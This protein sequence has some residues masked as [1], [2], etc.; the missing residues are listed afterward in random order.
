MRNIIKLLIVLIAMSF[1]LSAFAFTP[2]GLLEIHY[3]NVQTG[4]ATL[5]IGPDGT[6]LLMDAGENGKGYGEVIPYMQSIGLMPADDLD[7]MIAGHLHSDH[8]GGLDEVIYSGYNVIGAVYYSG[9]STWNSVVEDF[10]DAAATTTA[11]GPDVMALNTVIDLGDGATARCV[12]ANGSVLGGGYVSGSNE[13]DK[14]IAILVTYGEFEYIFASDLSGGDDDEWCTYRHTATNYANVETPLSNSLV[15]PSGANL[16]GEDGLEVMHV[17][18]HGSESST[19]NDYMDNL[20]PSVAC[21][22]VGWNQPDGWDFPRHDILDNVLLAEAPGG[23][24]DADPAMVFQTEEGSGNPDTYRSDR[25]YAVGDIIITTNGERLFLVDGTGQVSGGSDERSSAGLPRYFPLDE[26]A[27]DIIDPDAITNLTANG[28]PGSDEI[29]LNWTA[30]GDDGGSGTAAVYDIRYRLASSGPIDGEIDWS[31]SDE[32]ENEP[33]PQV[34]GSSE[35]FTIS[36]LTEGESYYFAIK[37]MDDNLN[38]SDL[39]N[40]PQA[41]AG[42]VTAGFNGDMEFWDD[43]GPSGPPDNWNVQTSSITAIREETTVHGGNYSTEVTWTSPTQADCEFLSNV[44]SITAEEFYTCSLYVYDND[45]AGHVALYY[46]WDTGN[47]WGPTTY[48]SDL[49]DWQLLTFTEQAPLGATTL[50][51]VFRCYDLAAGWDGDATIYLDDITLHE[52]IVGNQPPEFG[53]IFRYPYPIVYPEDDVAVRAEI[54]DDGPLAKD[55]LYYQMSSLLVYTAVGHD[56]IGTANED[57][58]WYTI[59]A[60]SI[61]TLIEFYVIAEDDTSQRIESSV[62]SY[63]VSEHPDNDLTNGDFELWTINGAGGPPDNWVLDSGG[64]TATQEASN[65]HGGNYSCNITWTSQSTQTMNSD[66][67]TIIAGETYVCSVYVYDND[68]AGRFRLCFISDDGNSYPDY[69]SSDQAGWQHLGY[70]WVAP[71]GATWVVVQPRMYDVSSN[72]DGNATVYIDDIVFSDTTSGPDDVTIYD[73]QFNNSQQG[74]DCYDSPLNG[75]VTPV[76]GTVAAVQQGTYPNYFLQ[77]CS[78]SQWNGVYVYDSTHP[79]EL[80]DNVTITAEVDE[81]YGLTELKNVAILETNSTGNALCTT[82]VTSDNISPACNAASEAYEGMLVRLNDVTC[83]VAPSPSGL[84][85]IKSPGAID[86][87][88]FD[89]EMHTFGGDH[90]VDF[91]LGQTYEYVIGVVHYAYDEYKL[92]PRF[93]T[94]VVPVPAEP[95]LIANIT[96]YPDDPIRPDDIVVVSAE[97]T[98]DGTI[99]QDSLYIETLLLEF[100]PVASDSTVGNIYWYTIGANDSGTTVNYYIVAVDDQEQRSQSDTLSY[101]CE[102]YGYEAPVIG[103][104]AHY[105][106]EPIRPDDNVIVSAEITDDGTIV[107]DSLYIESLTT[108]FTPVTSDSIVGD[109]YWYTIGLND[110]GTTVN[111]YVIAVDDNE[112]RTEASVYSYEVQG[113]IY[114]YAYLPGDVNMANGA[115]SPSVIGG[116]V[117]YLVNYFRGMPSSPSCLLDGFWASADANGDCLVIGSDVTKLV[118]YFRGSTELTYCADYAPLW[119][120]PEDLPAEAPDGWPNC[121]GIVVTGKIIESD[122]G[123]K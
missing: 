19:N 50:E 36:G 110:S 38:N 83:V 32:A 78:I 75:Q 59:P 17:N 76:T 60:A 92:L 15:S 42:L 3:I 54:I 111:Y 105:P 31:L 123:K 74:A 1:S 41:T 10:F 46:K 28:G 69:Y 103:E 96:R 89:D 25:G 66:P 61:G 122:S 18:H 67:L 57:Y 91:E 108:V 48:N 55:S 49:A 39:S 12:A 14:S 113:P 120:T 119:P 5:V 101:V 109:I 70:T 79:L 71:L 51:V 45:P 98:D 24:V 94:D 72:W 35:S 104:V 27:D 58:Y 100:S 118:N 116:D 21:I 117:T 97:I 107:E 30:T 20:T 93:A 114:G 13:N 121:D 85:Y 99:V 81:Y 26:D 33:E 64:F 44:I 95:P 80:G 102:G 87:C 47:S 86:S 16:L 29:T 43:N 84:G 6:T 82:L 115:W 9:S 88:A 53:D 2:S 11:G 56:S 40:S 34:A 4:G 90:P 22:S 62:L 63:S 73:I 106:A 37:V 52:G 65:V 68:P 8:I 77:D 23:C 112:M 7:Y